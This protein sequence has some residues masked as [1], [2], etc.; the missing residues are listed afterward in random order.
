MLTG[1]TS[2]EANPLLVH[3]AR[4]SSEKRLPQDCKLLRVTHRHGS[5]LHPV[6]DWAGPGVTGDSGVVF[7]MCVCCR[8]DSNIMHRGNP[9]YDPQL[10]QSQGE[11]YRGARVYTVARPNLTVLPPVLE[12][13]PAYILPNTVAEDQPNYQNFKIGEPTYVSPIPVSIYQNLPLINPDPVE[14]PETCV[15]ENVSPA[16]RQTSRCSGSSDYEDVEFLP[17]NIE[18]N[19]ED[20]K[21]SNEPTYVNTEQPRGRGSRAETRL[22]GFPC[23]TL[24]GCDYAADPL[25]AGSD[26]SG[27]SHILPPVCPCAVSAGG[28]MWASCCNWFCLDAAVTVE[29]TSRVQRQAYSNSGYSSYPSPLSPEHVCKACGSRFD[30]LARKHVCVD[31]RKNFCSRCSAQQDLRPRLCHTCQRFHGTLLERAEL[32]KL[33]VK[34]LRDYLHLHG[35]STQMCREKEEL[36]EL[37]LGQ[38]TPVE[39]VPRPDAPQCPV[40]PNPPAPPPPAPPPA[41]P[42]PQP[43]APEDDQSPS[44][45]V[46][47]GQ[48]ETPDSEVDTEGQGERE[49]QSSDVE[50]TAAPGRRASLSDLSGVEDIDGLSVRQLKEILARNFVNYK[51]CCEKWELMERVTRLYNEQQDLQNLVSNTGTGTDLGG[52]PGVEENMCKICMD[53]PIDCVLLECGHMVTCTK[54]GKRMSECPI[55]RQYVVRA[56]HVFRS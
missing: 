15:Y 43:L 52:P 42:S 53:L 39:E 8:K 14:D 31:C 23:R 22:P 32:M 12:E 40:P 19:S 33:K 28:S 29:E 16:Q 24:G 41:E 46:P 9:I 54:C 44:L 3:L 2:S 11:T 36:V 30:S 25:I 38:Q 34:D 5:D 51:G 7:A 4:P 6:R 56:V 50:E 26:N 20:M 13:T 37:V 45:P 18:E 21:E 27:A 48:E 10:F 35:V 1:V 49:S 47:S 55:C 17:R